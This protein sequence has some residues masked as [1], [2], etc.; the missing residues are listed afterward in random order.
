MKG[1][2]LSM[3][4]LLAGSGLTCTCFAAVVGATDFEKSAIL[5][6]LS[7]ASA[8][9]SAVPTFSNAA[10]IEAGASDTKASLTFAGY[11][12]QTVMGNYLH[13]ELGGDAPVS[14][15]RALTPGVS[16]SSCPSGRFARG[17]MKDRSRTM[18]A[19]KQKPV[20]DGR[21]VR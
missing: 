15:L 20:V 7:A 4:G 6:P 13:Y 17:G 9:S 14:G 11:L 18:R 12:P 8:K 19:S 5:E 16:D 1:I 3:A 21:G 10:S 2:I